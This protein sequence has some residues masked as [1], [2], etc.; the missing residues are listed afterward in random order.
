MAELNFQDEQGFNQIFKP[1]GSTPF[2]AQRRHEWFVRE[3][4]RLGARRILELGCGT[5]EA[6]A[7]MATHCNADVVAVDVS[8]KFLG[9]A[10]KTHTASNLHFHKLDI[11]TDDLKAIGTFDLVYGNGIL[12]HLVVRLDE[13]LRA[14]LSL[15]TP[16]GGLA[17][18]EPNFLN[19]YCA[20][21]FGTKIGRNFARLEPDEMAFKPQELRRSLAQAG[22]KHVDV[23]TRDFL[24]PG[25]PKSLIKPIL[26]IEPLLEGSIATRWLAQSH[27]MTARR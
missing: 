14:L 26:A 1:V 12:H 24:V 8:E 17:F 6:A 16:Q 15:T 20:F 7:F 10:R 22:W 3:A 13:V 5:G 9:S 27:F 2:R 19:P 11:F 23:T 18:I 25:V 21:I 4:R